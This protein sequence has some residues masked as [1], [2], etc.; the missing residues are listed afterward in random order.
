MLS[1]I[2]PLCL[3]SHFLFI[4][5]TLI[6]LRFMMFFIYASFICFYVF[7]LTTLP[8]RKYSIIVA[9]NSNYI[10][11]KNSIILKQQPP[12]SLDVSKLYNGTE[13][14]TIF[15]FVVIRVTLNTPK[16]RGCFRHFILSLNKTACYWAVGLKSVAHQYTCDL[17]RRAQSI[18]KS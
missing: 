11:Q 3:F 15:S 6:H 14:H 4:H 8:V 2:C 12:Q 18:Q 9:Q 5:D 7:S 10:L 13:Q 16:D 17:D 1:I